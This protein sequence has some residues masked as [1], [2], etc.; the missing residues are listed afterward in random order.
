M[1]LLKS[2]NN[3]DIDVAQLAVNMLLNTMNI[4][5]IENL[6]EKTIYRVK[7]FDR[8]YIVLQERYGAGLYHQMKKGNIIGYSSRQIGKTQLLEI[9]ENLYK[10]E[11]K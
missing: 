2:L 3:S 1:D 5:E 9:F 6:L 8:K 10:S 11:S 7:T 4:V